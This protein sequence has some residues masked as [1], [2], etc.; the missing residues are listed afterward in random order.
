LA[1]RK[2]TGRVSGSIKL[3]GV[4]AT[5]LSMARAGAFAEQFDAHLPTTTVREALHFSVALRTTP[6]QLGSGGAAGTVADALETLEMSRLADRRVSTLSSGELKRLSLGVELVSNK[7][8]IFAGEE[9]GSM[10]P[11]QWYM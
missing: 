10:M 11:P 1:F 6:E 3:N 8:L 7:G 9:C 5:A 2:T 4:D